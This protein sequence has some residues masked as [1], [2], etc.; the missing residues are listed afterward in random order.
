MTLQDEQPA[1][2]GQ[3]V[4]RLEHAQRLA[5]TGMSDE[6]AVLIPVDGLDELRELPATEGAALTRDRDER[7]LVDG[8]VAV[9]PQGGEVG[10]HERVDGAGQGDDGR[11]GGIRHAQRFQSVARSTRR[12]GAVPQSEIQLVGGGGEGWCNATI[13]TTGVARDCVEEMPPGIQ[14]VRR[15]VLAEEGF[16]HREEAVTDHENLPVA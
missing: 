3:V 5:G 6:Q 11:S 8:S 1:R 2:P 15:L 16:D 14:E 13:Q 10:E 4:D 9:G 7:R 12:V